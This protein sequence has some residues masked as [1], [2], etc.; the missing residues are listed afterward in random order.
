MRAGAA[1]AAVVMEAVARAAAGT[2]AAEKVAERAAVERVVVRAAPEEL[3]AV[4]M[5][6]PVC[7]QRS[8]TGRACR[9]TG[10]RQ[11]LPA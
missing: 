8:R 1:T 6:S 10:A 11:P 3:T 5:A 2:V 4:Q 9:S 7:W